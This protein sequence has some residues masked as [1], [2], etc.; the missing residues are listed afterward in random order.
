[1][2]HRK[3]KK[4][5]AGA[6]TGDAHRRRRHHTP[7]V[8]PL[9]EVRR[10]VDAQDA[11]R[12]TEL[13][14]AVA[15][16]ARSRSARTDVAAVWHFFAK[17]ILGRG[18]WAK[19]VPIYS[20]AIEF[21][22]NLPEDERMGTLRDERGCA[23]RMLRRLDEAEEDCHA[24]LAIHRR[25][26]SV[27]G[28]ARALG[29]LCG[30][31]FER[32]DMVSA[33]ALAREALELDRKSGDQRSTAIDL[34]GLAVS[35]MNQ[36]K[37]REAAEVAAELAP[38]ARALGDPGIEAN[39]LSLLANAALGDARL[40]EAEAF[41][42]RGRALFRRAGLLQNEGIMISNLGI[43]S[44]D[45]GRPDEADQ[46]FSEALHSHELTGDL[47]S[48]ANTLASRSL[49]R[50]DQG[51]FEEAQAD[52]DEALGLSTRSGM[53]WDEAHI[54]AT[55]A[56]VAEIRGERSEARV[57]YVEA[58][59]AH[60]ALGD[61][62]DAARALCAA[63]GLEADTG[64]PS[65]GDEMLARAAGIDPPSASMKRPGGGVLR[66]LRAISEGRIHAARARIAASHEEATA[67][68]S[69]A[70]ECLAE[71]ECA[72]LPYTTR[73]AEVRRATIRLLVALGLDAPTE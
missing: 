51:R 64:N 47:R 39:S 36:G 9:D 11:E 33:E 45:A 67:H 6:A 8:D 42:E 58:A 30:L 21:Y 50:A 2:A 48:R 29:N 52:L 43:L 32:G 4:V 46:R 23:L 18:E 27:I 28:A 68:R 65:A 59:M 61:L 19:A 17:G 73:N 62:A 60:E 63:A 7:R 66:A 3:K 57:W 5:N 70:E 12:A 34:H 44:L 20:D 37:T 31:A 35:L 72:E 55:L 22:R 24:A 41:Y 38:I 26:R 1:M 54:R 40:D 56:A 15:A 49:L 14:R 25:T 10:A 71:V 16:S 53:R 13:L 69:R